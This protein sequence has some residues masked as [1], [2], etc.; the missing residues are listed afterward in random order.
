MSVY[1]ESV[2]FKNY[3]QYKDVIINL[4]TT[5]KKLNA[6]VAV[7]GTGKTT[8]LNGINWCLYAQEP[9]LV[10]KNKAQPIVNESVIET[11]DEGN[12]VETNVTINLS[13]PS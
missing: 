13:I 5:E 2:K 12:T 6:I 10:G 9:N 3:R 1:I 4:N 11:I 7:N 8:F